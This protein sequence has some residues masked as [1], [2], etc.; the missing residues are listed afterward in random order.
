MEVVGLPTDRLWLRRWAAEDREPFAD[1]NADPLVMEH[2]PA[3]LS[4]RASDDLIDRIED[5]FE[6]RGLGL[7]AVEVVE[8]GELAGYVGLWPATFDAHFTPAI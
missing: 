4:R 8:T 2:Y 3:P 1:L 7:W 5:T 6:Q